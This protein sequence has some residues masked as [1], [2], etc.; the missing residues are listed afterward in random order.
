MNTHRTGKAVQKLK[1][2]FGILASGRL[3]GK[4]FNIVVGAGS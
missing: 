3:V 2:M 1:S 4:D